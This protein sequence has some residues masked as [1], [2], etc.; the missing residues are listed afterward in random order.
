M[1]IMLRCR[2]RTRIYHQSSSPRHNR[3]TVLGTLVAFRFGRIGVGRTPIMAAHIGS[4]FPVVAINMDGLR[5]SFRIEL[6]IV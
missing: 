4:V 5:N 1:P 3:A 2:V 6:A